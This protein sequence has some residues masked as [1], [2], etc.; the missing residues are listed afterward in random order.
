MGCDQRVRLLLEG[1][2]HGDSNSKAIHHSASRDDSVRLECS[3]LHG[4][5]AGSEE[6]AG[7]AEGS[8]LFAGTAARVS[9][10]IS[11]DECLVGRPVLPV[12]AALRDGGNV[13]LCVAAGRSRGL[14]AHRRHD[15]P[16]ILFGHEASAGTA[17]GGDVFA[18][19]VCGDGVLVPQGVLQLALP[20]GNGFGVFV[21][22]GTEIVLAKFSFAGLGGYSA[23]RVE[24]LAPGILLVGGFE[25]VGFGN[26]R[27]YAEPVRRGRGCKDAEFFP[28]HRDNRTDCAGGAGGSCSA[29]AELLVPV[30]VSVWGAAGV[31]VGVQSIADSA[32]CR[33][34][35]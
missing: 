28:V 29:G 22:A 7:P 34:L 23:A 21:E 1:K 30:S 13:G 12:G 26:C 17:S 20:G 5:I 18:G 14:A 33:D 15:E 4:K 27:I 32:G 31:S 10:C 9:V 6:E 16:E 25:H 8:R 3:L 35:H 19:D 2:S 11:P 24:V